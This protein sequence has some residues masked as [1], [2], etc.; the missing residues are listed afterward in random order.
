[1]KIQNTSIQFSNTTQ[2]SHTLSNI[3][4]KAIKNYRDEY[5][6]GLTDE[7]RKEIK[8]EIKAYLE[9]IPEGGKVD[10]KKLNDIVMKLLKTYGFKGNMEDMAQ[11]IIG[12]VVLQ[13][14]EESNVSKDAA[15]AYEKLTA[16]SPLPPF[17]TPS[18][19]ENTEEES[20]TQIITNSDGSKSLVTIKNHVILSTVK[21]EAT[22]PLTEQNTS[23]Y[24][25]S[26][27]SIA[28]LIGNIEKE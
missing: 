25:Q 27:D 3:M 20:I 9:S 6:T 24:I 17:N 26:T 1:M 18:S 4:T 19:L 7:E 16:G 15:I 21:L 10:S 23:T 5:L 22:S 11:I 14:H 12:E 28:S 8:K 13:L 2:G